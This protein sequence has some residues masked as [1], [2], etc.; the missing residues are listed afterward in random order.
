MVTAPVQKERHQRRRHRVH[1]PHRV[2]RRAHADSAH[3]VMLLV[4]RRGCGW[5]R[6]ALA[7]THLPL[8][9]V[10]A[11]ITQQ[12][13]RTTLRVVARI[14]ARGSASRAAHRRVRPE[15]ARGR[16]RLSRARGDRRHRAGDRRIARAPASTCTGPLPA[17]TVFVP[18]TREAIRLHR[19]HVPRPGAARAEAGEL[20]PWRQRHARAADR[21]H[22]GRSR[23]RARPRRRPG[24]GAVRRPGKP[25]R[26]DRAGDRA[27]DA[28]GAARARRTSVAQRAPT[29]THARMLGHP[30]RKRF[31]QNFLVDPHYIAR[32][33]AAIDPRPGDNLVEIG[34]GLG[35]LTRPLID[36]CGT[37][38]RDRDRSRPRGAAGR[39]VSRPIACS[40]HDRPTRS[41]FDFATLGQ[42][43]ARHR[44]PALQ[45]Q[46][47]AAV[48][49]RAIRCV[50]ARHHG[51]AAEGSRA[52]HGRSARRRRSTAGCR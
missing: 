19:R 51:D 15:P 17:D 46:L 38:H 32:I 3:V 30:S 11:A 28:T 34:P 39:R 5:L 20:R 2:P 43:L 6:V 27:R 18:H 42:R 7:T 8:A 29:S 44:Q 12:G 35:A 9:A 37:H 21:A 49:P 25:V 1:R 13:L 40:L 52:A 33:I 22:V 26:R 41:R 45:H 31:G 16:G 47:A 50:G 23:H 10:P 4:G 24:A 36:A 14:C 48:S